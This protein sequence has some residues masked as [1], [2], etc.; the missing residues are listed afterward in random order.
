MSTIDINLQADAE[1]FGLRWRPLIVA[2]R[3]LRDMF[4]GLSFYVD[5]MIIF[6]FQ[7]PVIILWITTVAFGGWVAWHILWWLKK[8]FVVKRMDEKNNKEE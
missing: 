1:V 8:F 7:L 6:L 2:K 3:A 5:K 4:T